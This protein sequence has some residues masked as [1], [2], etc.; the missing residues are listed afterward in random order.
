[1]TE[2]L[3]ALILSQR[4][5]QAR[6]RSRPGDFHSSKRH[7]GRI[8]PCPSMNRGC[9]PAVSLRRRAAAIIAGAGSSPVTIAPRRAS[10]DASASSP[11]PTSSNVFPVIEPSISERSCCSNVSVTWP[12]RLDLQRAQHSV[13]PMADCV[14][15][16][17][18][19]A[20]H[21]SSS[22]VLRRV[23]AIRASALSPQASMRSRTAEPC[24]GFVSTPKG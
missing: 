7:T 12:K 3:D 1:V 6:R 18:S 13:S 24:H 10:S 2:P 4:T 5:N 9:V 15:F 21:A 23:P 11:Q 8:S 16:M 17:G 14:L 22:I 19:F 20:P